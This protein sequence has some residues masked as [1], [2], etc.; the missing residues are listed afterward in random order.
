MDLKPILDKLHSAL[1]E[2][3]EPD[4]DASWYKDNSKSINDLI[5]AARQIDQTF[6]AV[7]EAYEFTEKLKEPRS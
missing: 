3:G 4:G 7:Q 5:E 2:L 1:E 6:V